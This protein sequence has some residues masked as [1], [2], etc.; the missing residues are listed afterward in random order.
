MI[1]NLLDDDETNCD[2][3]DRRAWESTKST[4]S[5]NV[6]DTAEET[7]SAERISSSRALFRRYSIERDARAWNAENHMSKRSASVGGMG[8]RFLL[9][10]CRAVNPTSA[11]CQTPVFMTRVLHSEMQVWN[12]RLTYVFSH[13]PYSSTTMWDTCRNCEK[14]KDDPFLLIILG[15]IEYASWPCQYLVI[16]ERLPGRK[17]A[18]QLLL[19][20]CSYFEVAIHTLERTEHTNW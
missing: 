19:A 7:W 17:P 8:K 14:T 15:L 20:Y 3:D 5:R 6:W 10:R 4:S 1:K 11:Y 13:S 9:H 18:P 12:F 2:Y 16:V